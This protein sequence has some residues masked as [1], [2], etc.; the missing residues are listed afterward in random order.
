MNIVRR[1]I[2]K[3]RTQNA[4]R[5]AVAIFRVWIR[6]H[7]G[8]PIPWHRKPLRMQTNP[9]N[10]R[11]KK[12]NFHP[13]GV[14]IFPYW[15]GRHRFFRS[16]HMS[17]DPCRLPGNLIHQR[18]VPIQLSAGHIGVNPPEIK[19]IGSADK[20]IGRKKKLGEI[21]DAPAF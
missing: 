5:C 18:T 2:G 14:Y 9:Q 8:L 17:S 10:I 12:L 7:R 21:L 1:G 11:N 20:L 4:R 15:Q 6:I 13:C 16:A 3:I 19:D